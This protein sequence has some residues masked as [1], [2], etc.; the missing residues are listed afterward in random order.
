MP[1]Y[2]P[3][4]VSILTR[5]CDRVQ[6]KSVTTGT[7]TDGFQSSPGLATGCNIIVLVSGSVVMWFQSSPGLATGCNVCQ[8]LRAGNNAVSI[9]TRPC[10]R[11]QLHALKTRIGFHA[12]GVSILTRPCDR[13]QPGTG[14]CDG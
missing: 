12:Q 5:P 1:S 10:D 11:V 9:L 2:V 13:V 6:L 7:R 8:S 3:I 4:I 14:D